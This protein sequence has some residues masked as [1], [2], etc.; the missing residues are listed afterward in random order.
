MRRFIKIKKMLADMVQGIKEGFTVESVSGD[1]ILRIDTR[2]LQF[3]ASVEDS[4]LAM[5]FV[6]D[7]IVER[8]SIRQIV[9]QGQ[10]NFLYLSEQV[11]MLKDVARIYHHLVKEQRIFS[12]GLAAFS[13]AGVGIVREKF[14][15]LQQLVMGL[16]R[17][18]PIGA[19]VEAKRALR[20]EQVAVKDEGDGARKKL[21]EQ[22]CDVLQYFVG[23][24]EQTSLVRRLQNELAGYHVGD[25]SIYRSVFRAQVQ[26]DFIFTRVLSELPVDGE[27]VKV[28]SVG[29]HQITLV[30]TNNDNR[31][32]YHVVPY[33]YQ[34]SEDMYALIDVA[35]QILGEHKPQASEFLD[36]RTVRR[37]FFNISKDLLQELSSSKGINL[38]YRE[39][40]ELSNVVVRYT[41]GFGLLEV[42]LLDKEVQDITINSPV[43]QSRMFILH[44]QYGECV[45][46]LLPSKDDADGWAT[47]FRLLSGR[48][49]DEANP[50]LDTELS[51]PGSRSRIAVIT[52]PLSP[53]GLGYA[54]R[55]HRD[56]PWTLALFVANKMISSEAAGLISFLVDGGRSMLFAGTRSSGKTS[57]M[58]AMMLEIMRKYRVVTLE[59]T[60]E[61]N[62]DAMRKMG[63]NIQSLKVR[64]ALTSGGI[65]IGAD[66]GIRTSLRLGDSSL[67]VGEI[68]SVE[69]KALFEAMRIG[70]LANVVA[71]TIHGASPYAVY[72]RVVNDLGVPSTSFKAIDCV[73][74]SNPVK[75]ADGLQSFRRV[76]QISEVRKHWKEDPLREGGFV[77]LFTYDSKRD[78][79]KMTPALLHGDSD[80]LKAIGALV[81]EWVGNW[82]ALMEQVY[83]RAKVKEWQVDT[84][85]KLQRPEL[86]EAEFTVMINDAFHKVSEEV[87]KEYG[88]AD[89]KRVWQ[90]FVRWGEKQLIGA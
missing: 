67:I 4:A 51:L 75:S 65:E 14:L 73:I 42:L 83:L 53:D 54:L 68:R 2:A 25:R 59:D 11:D 66:E 23:L 86:L 84:S 69:A 35:R 41:V 58:Q 39:L 56:E 90:S 44:S 6:I 37:T 38:S 9:F 46:N 15:V 34:V 13:E 30:R 33:E 62:V 50:V 29:P 49:L 85:I 48:P 10:R 36:T 47:K 20:E 31:L 88:S 17:E 22:F 26:P 12:G 5:A 76:L 79:I 87:R 64:S 18:D 43:G 3:P 60:L 78:E 82:D 28:Y 32:L 40:V 55:R 19:Y 70:A 21:R 57:L 74:V 61:I 81:P 77:D 24:L 8:P 80:V 89:A 71:G 1:D 45:T 63:Y 27:V 72:D 7:R 52:N 16:L